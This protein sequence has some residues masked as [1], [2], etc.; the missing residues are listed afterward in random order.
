MILIC[1]CLQNS[2][3]EELVDELCCKLKEVDATDQ[4]GKRELQSSKS[5]RK[6]RSRPLS[7]R[8]MARLYYA[9][10]PALVPSNEPDPGSLQSTSGEV[11]G[12]SFKSRNPQKQNSGNK[13][14]QRP[15][16]S[17]TSRDRHNAQAYRN[18]NINHGSH[19]HKKSRKSYCNTED[20]P[21]W[22]NDGDVWDMES[23]EHVQDLI[24][25]IDEGYGTCDNTV[26]DEV[27]SSKR[28]YERD[29]DTFLN[30]DGDEI[31]L[32]KNW[33][34][35]NYKS[36]QKS[37]TEEESMAKFKAKFDR[38]LE[39]LWPK[40]QN[41]N[42]EYELPLDFQ[43]ISSP[44]D[45]MFDCYSVDKPLPVSLTSSIWS[46]NDSKSDWE[47]SDFTMN[48]EN[49]H[50]MNFVT[51]TCNKNFLP[52]KQNPWENNDLYSKET[53]EVIYKKLKPLNLDD[54]DETSYDI[55]N[56]NHPQSYNSSSLS[57]C[58]DECTTKE[59]NLFSFKLHQP[60]IGTP[61][62]S[63]NILNHSVYS[64]FTEVIPKA[65][66]F[67]GDSFVRKSNVNLRLD[68][69]KSLNNPEPDEKDDEDLLTSARTHFRPIKHDNADCLHAAVNYADGMTFPI[70]SDLD[71]VKFRRNNSGSIFLESDNEPPKRYM[72][73]RKQGIDYAR[74][75][76]SS[77]SVCSD[78]SLTAKDL[79]LKFKVCQTEKSVQTDETDLIHHP[80]PIVNV[81]LP[82]LRECF[83][84]GNANNH[85]KIGNNLDSDKE[86]ESLDLNWVQCDECKLNNNQ[87]ASDDWNSCKL[88]P[89][90]IWSTDDTGC[91]TCTEQAKTLIMHCNSGKDKVPEEETAREWDELYSDIRYIHDLVKSESDWREDLN[92]PNENC[93]IAPNEISIKALD[94]NFVKSA[95]LAKQNQAVDCLLWLNNGKRESNIVGKI[96]DHSLIMY[97]KVEPHC[98]AC[99]DDSANIE[100]IT[101]RTD[102]KRRHSAVSGVKAKAEG[103]L[104]CTLPGQDSIYATR[105]MHMPLLPTAD[106]PLT[107]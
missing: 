14:C 22:V 30:I 5:S 16:K 11:S 57:K 84:S 71:Y 15:K 37:P 63:L 102:R 58:N 50:P 103:K 73:Y 106:R 99:I 23:Q 104:R 92:T 19:K 20:L 33:D 54:S 86:L 59:P 101:W 62:R 29:I 55:K 97:S 91:K 51:E 8:E 75:D 80:K 100:N 49:F 88:N 35:D 64:S 42:I 65:P 24:K 66:G 68:L 72:E 67:I 3:I 21:E 107:R 83:E 87:W 77:S 43:D 34:Y 76:I 36:L 93:Y 46:N 32:S 82:N 47:T 39:A 17:H 1:K 44:S 79:I 48:N 18:H 2:G 95:L 38:S 94:G 90:T 69:P 25:G 96:L 85:N 98:E 41:N 10:F 7:P 40:E 56:A 81:S 4:G 6:E 89:S 26:V 27:P 28:L 12:T 31:T 61:A 53:M 78:D 105:P 74:L 60:P 9:A 45:R 70:V 52:I 13:D